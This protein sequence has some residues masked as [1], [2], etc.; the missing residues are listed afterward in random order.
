[1]T[2]TSGQAAEFSGK[3]AL[4]VDDSKSARAF[5]ARML[6][7]HGI[8]VDTAETAEQ[9]IVYLARTRPDVIFM[10]HLMPGMDGFQAVQSIKNNPRTATIPIMMFTSQE[11][12]L[13][14]GQARAL[15]ALGV[16]PKQ[17]KP[18]EVSTVLHQL[19]LVP[20]RRR[21]RVTSFEPG[22]AVAQEAFQRPA[23]VAVNGVA[24]GAATG[25][26]GPS[27]AP[28]A[29]AAEPGV[30][31]AQLRPLVEDV[32]RDQLTDLRRA[33]GNMLDDH[34]ERVLAQVRESA[35]TATVTAADGTDPAGEALFVAHAPAPRPARA[36]WAIAAG[37]SLV[38]AAMAMLWWQETQSSREL[39]AQ[40]VE[41]RSAL[42]ARE[43]A[44]NRAAAALVGARTPEPQLP[45]PSNGPAA[46]P[47][48]AGG[49]SEAVQ[50]VPYGEVPISGERLEALRRQLDDL[51]ARGF[52]GT[53]T[54]TSFPG[55]YCLVGSL[56]EGYQVA[57][58]DAPLS[59]CDV[60][61]NPFDEQLG[62]AQREP[63]ALANLVGAIRQKS[64]GALQVQ[65]VNGSET[66][67]VAAY[68]DP[69]ARATAGDWNRS[70]ASN[71]RV[72]I[73]IQPQAP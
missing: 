27:L 18:A 16:L 19:R 63:L 6:E 9:A 60:L 66:Q 73:R 26:D 58:A 51:V 67:R 7:K 50:L 14:L 37:V 33:L 44:A 35:G 55:R 34:T 3:R 43:A 12:E 56:T 64:G 47:P 65:L 31:A 62:P 29:A 5:L 42:T 1:M 4:I 70:A 2:E 20:D 28:P 36:P 69:S 59:R 68:P 11:G 40:L 54:V 8:E 46:A 45:P 23:L 21:A 71:N 13:Y 17:V 57:P 30:S 48:P 53:V 10:D 24:T 49:A 25:T 61:G 52:R 39:A 22:N 15:G 72:E 41:A 38:A 32:V